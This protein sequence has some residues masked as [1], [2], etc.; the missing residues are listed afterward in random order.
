MRARGRIHP[1][2][3]GTELPDLAAAKSH[4]SAVAE[5]LMR[6]SDGS[7]RHWSMRVEEGSG[8]PQ[9]DLFFADVDQRLA[10]YPPQARMLVTETCRRLSALTDVLCAAR[11]TRTETRMLLARARRKPQLVYAKG[12]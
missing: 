5:E 11:E 2:H 4:A 8:E 3:E 7:T 1:D 6:H 10:S 9:F 12:E